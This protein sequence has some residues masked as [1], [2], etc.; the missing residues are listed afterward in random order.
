MRGVDEQ[1]LGKK[2]LSKNDP[3]VDPLRGSCTLEVFACPAQSKWISAH[4]MADPIGSSTVT[5]VAIPSWQQLSHRLPRP[6][7]VYILFV[8]GLITR[9]SITSSLQPLW[10]SQRILLTHIATPYPCK[11][12][13]T[14]LIASLCVASCA[15]YHGHAPPPQVIF[16]AHLVQF[17]TPTR[18]AEPPRPSNSKLL[19][20]L[21]NAPDTLLPLADVPA[22]RDLQ[23]TIQH[24]MP[25]ILELP[26]EIMEFIFRHII[27]S[28]TPTRRRNPLHYSLS[29]EITAAPLRLVCRAWANMLYEHHLYR[30]LVFSSASQS[31]AF[32]DYL[33]R[34]PRNLPRPKCQYLV[35]EYIWPFE[36]APQSG[37]PNT[38]N[39]EV[40]ESLLELFS[41]SVITLDL[42]F[43]EYFALPSQTIKAIG[44]INKLE[45]LRLGAQFY[46]DASE[47]DEP[48]EDPACFNS[49]MMQAQGLKSLHLDIPVWLPSKPEL[50]TGIQ[51]PAIT[52]L[53]VDST[54]D[55]DPD[56]LLGISI[57]LKPSLKYLSL[58][59]HA[60]GSDVQ[61]VLPLYEILRENIEGLSVIH[62]NSYTP[63]LQLSFPKLRVLVIRRWLHPFADLLNQGLFSQASIEIVAI[64]P[65]SAEG[66]SSN[67]TVDALSKLPQLR[68]LV[69]MNTQ[70]DYSPPHGYLTAC[71]A[72]H[73]NCIYVDH[74]ELCD[75]MKL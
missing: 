28:N 62:I 18:R 63:L 72:R 44:R 11:V 60:L 45:N 69:F 59:C 21:A 71:E 56:V 19:Q 12:L 54:E 14:F 10:A 1:L 17:L 3:S 47:L 26:R 68:K 36:Y 2:N 40:L 75:I 53:V 5:L 74:D 34:R 32:I 51:Y 31:S 23:S 65:I 64:D 29:V 22:M 46:F 67:F 13:S 8:S 70:P 41:D 35:V 66:N 4:G 73:I 20:Y 9:E 25:N 27:T 30:T 7:H 50:M 58:H 37:I 24:K 52:H 15:A 55:F 49:L 38:I 16:I 57:A 48:E 43:L 42:N 6:R 39:S 33:G 61:P